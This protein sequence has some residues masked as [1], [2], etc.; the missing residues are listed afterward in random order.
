MRM[1]WA[2]RRRTTRREDIAYCLFGLFDVNM[3][4][5][6][7]EGEKAFTRLQLEVIRKSDDE[8]IFA[9]TSDSPRWGML[10]P[11]PVSFQESGSIIRGSSPHFSPSL[12]YSMTNKGLEIR[13]SSEARC[14]HATQSNSFGDLVTIV[15]AC[16]R[17]TTHQPRWPLEKTHYLTICLWKPDHRSHWERVHLDQLCENDVSTLVPSQVDTFLV[18]QPGL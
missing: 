11:S 17:L 1:S 2:S 6:Y 14:D 12:P 3:P 10:A 15:I 9:W 16:T 8:S 18:H 13:K 4:L 5:L 7:G